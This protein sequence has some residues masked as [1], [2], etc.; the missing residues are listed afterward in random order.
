MNL[1]ALHSCINNINVTSYDIPVVIVNAYSAILLFV[2]LR[3]VVASYLMGSG[4]SYIV[5]FCCL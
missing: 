3:S 5:P 1:S 2:V 4:Y